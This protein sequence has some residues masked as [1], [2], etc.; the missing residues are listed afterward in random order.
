MLKRMS[1]I[2]EKL[3]K[4]DDDESAGLDTRVKPIVR[5]I[6]GALDED[7]T[8][9]II[10]NGRVATESLRF[11][12]V[13]E[14]YQRTSSGDRADIFTALQDRVVV[15]NIEVGIRGFDFRCEGADY[16]IEAPCFVIDGWQRVSTAN[17]ILELVPDR[18]IRL[19]ATA[20]F[21]S[22]PE[23]EAKRFNDLNKNIKKVSANLHLRNMRLSNDA[24]LTLYGLSN[25]QKDCPLHNR[26]AWQ[27]NKR[28][29]ELISAMQLATTAIWLHRH[30]APIST[31]STDGVAASLLTAYRAV[32]PFQFR[33]NVSTFFEVIEECWGFRTIEFRNA[34]QIKTTF[35]TQLARMFAMHED[36]WDTGERV[37][38]VPAELRR[39][40]SKFPVQ[41]P[42]IARLA[43]A[44]GGARNLLYDHLVNHVNSGKRTGQL[45]LRGAGRS[46]AA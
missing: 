45:R 44:S 29:G 26:V 24:I 12:K 25:N 27:Q 28:R 3:R 10:L 15:P 17:R 21:G 20:H 39:K 41:D 11:L 7:E 9:S 5:I 46:V 34:P 37:F 32:G 30:H 19:F 4:L 2:V 13:D 33:R 36:F 35:M 31:N 43:G 23:F 22:N 14:T 16:L 42:M 8:G 6:N 40:L 18:P 1:D 38:F